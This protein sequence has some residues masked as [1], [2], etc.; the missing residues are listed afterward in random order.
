MIETFLCSHCGRPHPIYARYEMD[1]SL[2][3]PDCLEEHTVICSHCGQRI[4][5]SDNAGDGN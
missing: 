2:L 3:C 1:G 4:W 5:S